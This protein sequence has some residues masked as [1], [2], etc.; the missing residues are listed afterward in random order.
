MGRLRDRHCPR[1][2]SHTVRHA[3][4]V[5]GFILVAACSGSA[6]STPQ[7]ALSTGPSDGSLLSATLDLPTTTLRAGG[8]LS[9]RINIVNATGHA[10]HVIGCGGLFDGLLTSPTYHP[11]PAWSTCAQK[12]TIP[13]GRSSQPIHV[14]ASFNSCGHGRPTA[15]MPTCTSTGRPPLPTGD[16]TATGFAI[17]TALPR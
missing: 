11:M 7:A 14:E 1:I 12:F 15:T 17:S 3:A 10:L 8:T 13:T 6:R 5:A 4:A 16:Y 9:G 2:V